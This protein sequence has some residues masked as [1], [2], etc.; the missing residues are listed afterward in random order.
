MGSV[1]ASRSCASK[2]GRY[3]GIG[4]LVIE[5]RIVLYRMLHHE[6]DHSCRWLGHF[7]CSNVRKRC[8]SF[9]WFE[10][11]SP[12]WDCTAGVGLFAFR[13][14]RSMRLVLV[15][16][17]VVCVL[18]MDGCLLRYSDISTSLSH[19]LPAT[20][21]LGS[22]PTMSCHSGISSRVDGAMHVCLNDVVFVHSLLL[23]T[24]NNIINTG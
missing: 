16:R 17:T 12:F 19:S 13:C 15:F 9:L 5:V 7:A 20:L 2:P 6:K 8:V 11:C 4:W 3:F 1:D 22:H 21:R 24:T 10:C 23:E 14:V 18:Q